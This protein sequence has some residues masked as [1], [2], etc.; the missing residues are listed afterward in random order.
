M[1]G[2][3]LKYIEIKLR[4]CT[5]YLTVD[6]AERLLQLNPD[7]YGEAIRRGK[8]SLRARQAR[9]RGAVKVRGDQK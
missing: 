4:R 6:E 5:V 9:A 8:A 3:R 7:L 1:P 2:D